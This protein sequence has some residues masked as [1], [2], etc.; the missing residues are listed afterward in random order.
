MQTY[1]VIITGA[2]DNGLVPLTCSKL[3]TACCFRK[4]VL[5]PGGAA[6]TEEVIPLQAPG[7][8]FNLCAIDREFINLGPVVSALD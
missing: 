1:D 7:F 6:T 2:G 8:K 3:G 5:S 4:S